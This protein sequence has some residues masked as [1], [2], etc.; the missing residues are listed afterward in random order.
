MTGDIALKTDNSTK[1]IPNATPTDEL[2]APKTEEESNMSNTDSSSQHH[3]QISTR[4]CAKNECQ[5]KNVQSQ[6]PPPKDPG[7]IHQ[8]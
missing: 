8:E 3:H 4:T 1:A 7:E 6:T 2:A 5:G